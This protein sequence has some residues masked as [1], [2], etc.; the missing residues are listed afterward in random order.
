[1]PKVTTVPR[2]IRG[3]KSARR[4]RLHEASRARP[5]HGFAA[6]RPKVTTVPRKIHGSKSARRYRQSP[7]EDAPATVSRS[8]RPKVATVPRKIHWSKSARRYRLSPL[9]YAPATVSRPSRPKVPKATTVPCK[10]RGSKSARRYRLHEAS[11][12]RPRHGFAAPR[13]KVTTV[14]Q[15]P[16]VQKR[17]PLPLA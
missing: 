14:T 8:S 9:E 16:R 5:R 4:Y 6:P 11:R 13:P 7:L 17:A 3:S 15:N 12:A 2:K 10:I 1:M